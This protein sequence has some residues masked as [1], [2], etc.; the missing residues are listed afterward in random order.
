VS[1]PTDPRYLDPHDPRFELDRQDNLTLLALGEPVDADF[2]AH[3]TS[4]PQCQHDLAALAQT[5]T[6]ARQTDEHSDAQPP[7]SIWLDISTELGIAAHRHSAPA[8]PIRHRM[9]WR[10]G[11]AAAAMVVTLAAA[12]GGYLLGRHSDVPAARAGSHATLRAQ[13]GAPVGVTGT[14]VVHAT[15]KGHQLTVD[16]S[17]LPLREGYYEVWLYNP[18]SGGMQPVGAL[19]DDG[20]GTFTVAGSIDL[21]SYNVIDISAQDYGGST[22]VHQH[23]VLQGPLT[24]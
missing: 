18:T 11:L 3:Q 5:V 7:P 6:L 24:Q 17:G 19:A 12:G 23:S 10:T 9:R 16:S 8:L 13:P 14:A 22:V 15:A 20:S 4:C 21:R 1:S 2:H